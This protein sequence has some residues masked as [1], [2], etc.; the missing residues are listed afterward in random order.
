MILLY[1]RLYA[2]YEANNKIDKSNISGSKRT[3]IYKQNPVGNAY[4]IISQLN[5]VLQ[6]DYFSSPVGYD[7]NVWFEN[8]KIKLKNKMNLLLKNTKNGFILKQEDE[9][10]YRKTIFIG[11]VELIF[12]LIRLELHVN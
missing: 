1:C 3:N 12:F 5:E 4:Y 9:K 8:G 10:D 7:N 6:S 11:F 2:D